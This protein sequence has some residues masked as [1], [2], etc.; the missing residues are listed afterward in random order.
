MTDVDAGL[1]PHALCRDGSILCGVVHKRDVHGR[2]HRHFAVS[3][4]CGERGVDDAI[5]SPLRVSFDVWPRQNAPEDSSMYGIHACICLASV[6]WDAAA[7]RRCVAAKMRGGE[8][9]CWA[10]AP[11]GRQRP[12][13]C[14]EPCRGT[15]ALSTIVIIILVTC[16]WRWQR[17]RVADEEAAIWWRDQGAH[18]GRGVALSPSEEGSGRERDSSEHPEWRCCNATSRWRW[19]PSR[20][21]GGPQLGGGRGR[22]RHA[23]P[24]GDAAADGGGGSAKK[25][26]IKKTKAASPKPRS[27][28]RGAAPSAPAT[29][30][31]A[32]T[33]THGGRG[34]AGDN[35]DIEAEDQSSVED[36]R[37]ALAAM[38]DQLAALKAELLADEAAAKAA[39]GAAT[40][41]MA[42]KKA[43]TKT[44]AVTKRCTRALDLH[45]SVAVDDRAAALYCAQLSEAVYSN[46]VIQFTS[47]LP[48]T[49]K[50]AVELSAA[51]GKVPT[52]VL[53][54]GMSEKNLVQWGVFQLK[55]ADDR[56]VLAVVFR[57]SEYKSVSELWHD[58]VVTDFDVFFPDTVDVPSAKPRAKVK[59]HAGFNRAYK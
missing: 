23:R 44:K 48:R 9:P 10:E 2:L 45:T 8:D 41:K 16:S 52:V 17:R 40:A 55:W 22:S 57:G 47:T 38:A 43:A 53:R 4:R 35:R 14:R 39:K 58:W 49:A 13:A 5:E 42:A 34:S 33:T 54:E 15:L 56:H 25:V 24:A 27:S 46:A 29:P 50:Q 20:R 19:Q 6:W 11:E 31:P 18:A 32:T 26:M 1:Q 59:L 28:S 36:R 51:A 12:W 37:V 21:S 3:R 7:L 30:G